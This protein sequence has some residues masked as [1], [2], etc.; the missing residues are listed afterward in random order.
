MAKILEKRK[1]R[2]D[3]YFFRL[4]TPEIAKKAKAG[5]FI[6]LILH[7]HGERIPISLADINPEDG[8]VSI[9]F[10]TV[11][12]TSTEMATFEVGDE[13]AD[14]VGPLGNPSHVKNFGKVVLVGGGFGV[15]PLYPIAK[16]LKAA[17]NEIVTVMGARNADLL[18]Y[19]EEMAATSD[20]VLVTTDDGSKGIKGVVTLALED[21]LKAGVDLVL[22][23]GPAIMMKFVAKT[24]EPYNV[25]TIVSLN[26]IMVDGTGMCGACRVSIGGETKFGCTDGPEFDGHLVDWDLL[27]SRQRMYLKEEKEAM[28]RYSCNCVPIS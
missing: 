19:E 13:I 3:V 25:K 8:S 9:M 2:P 17:G 4:S 22:A 20:K 16:A 18:L 21:E 28:E 10:M 24:T 14:V 5:Q 27:M 12:K 26:P 15:A 11:G 23:V 7:E 6:I 1:V